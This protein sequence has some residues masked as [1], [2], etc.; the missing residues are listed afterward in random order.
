MC[1]HAMAISS[2]AKFLRQAEREV[3]E[4]EVDLEDLR[5]VADEV[6]RLAGPH[7]VQQARVSRPNMTLFQMKPTTATESTTGK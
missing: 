6:D 4:R 2:A 3:E 5:L 1:R 7:D